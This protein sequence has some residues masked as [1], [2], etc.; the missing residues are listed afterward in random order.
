M[1]KQIATSTWDSDI[2]PKTNTNIWRF[3]EESRPTGQHKPSTP[4]LQ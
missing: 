1:R 4:Q 2:A 3:K